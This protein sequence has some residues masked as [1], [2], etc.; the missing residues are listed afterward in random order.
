[1]QTPTCVNRLLAGSEV[2]SASGIDIS[3]RTSLRRGGGEIGTLDLQTPR[4]L[5]SSFPP[6]TPSTQN[7]CAGADT[8]YVTQSFLPNLLPSFT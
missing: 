8:G 1:M 2:V 6:Q 5:S 7:A 4:L 3:E